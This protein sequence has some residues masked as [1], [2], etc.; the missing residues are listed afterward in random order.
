MVF[1]GVFLV[2][3]CNG[4]IVLLHLLLICIQVAGELN[5]GLL[6]GGVLPLQLLLLSVE[7]GFLLL[8]LLL[9]VFVLFLVFVHHAA[10]LEEACRWGHSL[11]LSD[12]GTCISI[13]RSCFVH[14]VAHLPKA[15]IKILIIFH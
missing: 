6:D 4:Q 1:L 7:L 14:C 15:V 3:A 2:Q 8:E 10:L 9:F 13:L 5:K 12:D 11:I